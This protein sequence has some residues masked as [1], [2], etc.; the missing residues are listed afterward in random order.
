MTNLE[1][2]KNDNEMFDILK[3]ITFSFQ[4]I[5]TSGSGLFLLVLLP[6]LA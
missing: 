2:L 5:F 3:E 4:L 1:N 6:G